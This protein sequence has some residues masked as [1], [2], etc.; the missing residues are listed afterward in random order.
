MSGIG[1][2]PRPSPRTSR[3]SGPPRWQVPEV[4]GPALALARAVQHSV[5]ALR[6][7]GRSRWAE[8]LEPLV[9]PLQ[10][11]DLRAVRLAANRVRAAFG[12]GESVAEDLSDAD[13]RVLRDATDATLRALA[14]HDAI[15]ATRTG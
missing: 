9:D 7:A 3:A 4:D 1:S 8:V 10:D 14:R 15:S 12:V 11:G 2:G 13:A 6:T 5:D